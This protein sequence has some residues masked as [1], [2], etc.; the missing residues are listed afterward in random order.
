[1]ASNSIIDFTVDRVFKKE[2]WMGKT[3]PASNVPLELSEYRAMALEVPAAF[4]KALL[5]DPSISVHEFIACALPKAHASLI[6]LG[7]KSH[8]L[9]A[10][11]TENVFCLRTRKLPSRDFVEDAEA[12]LGQALL[13]GAQSIEDPAYKGTGL[14]VWTIQ[15]W[16]EMHIVLQAQ[17]R[18]K[19][20]DVW[21]QKYSTGT[22]AQPDLDQSRRHLS[23]LAWQAQTLVPGS[24]NSTTQDFARLLSNEM[25]TTT[26][27]DMMVEH[28]ANWVR[29]DEVLSAK[30]EVVGLVFMNDILKAMSPNAY[31]KKSPGFL[32][33]LE[34]KLKTCLKILLFPVH[35][36]ARIHFVAFEVDFEK[37]C[38]SYGKTVRIALKQKN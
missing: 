6:S 32:H 15:Y 31:K 25:L 24:N 1:M 33:K 17:A 18:W 5:P 13:N 30:F 37:K 28:I 7:A 20:G 35:L 2:D 11:P 10:K 36:P 8:F 9:R 23:S 12:C 4:R 19:K 21:L 3:Y 16:K 26:L 38:I 29:A 27:V 22:S 14:P 34:G